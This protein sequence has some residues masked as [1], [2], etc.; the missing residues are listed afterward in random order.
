MD[1]HVAHADQGQQGLESAELKFWDGRPER[2][3]FERMEQLRDQILDGKSS[4]WHNRNFPTGRTDFDISHGC[5][6]ERLEDDRKGVNRGM[7]GS[8]IS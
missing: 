5:Y 8:H 1:S 3:G 4:G 2:L 6:P 7:D